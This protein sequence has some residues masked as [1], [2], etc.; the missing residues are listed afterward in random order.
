MLSTESFVTMFIIIIIIIIIISFLSNLESE[1][2]QVSSGLSDSFTYFKR[3]QSYCGQESRFY[4]WF[5][6]SSFFFLNSLDPFQVQ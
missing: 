2:L 5:Q 1:W 4:F 3:S 6:I